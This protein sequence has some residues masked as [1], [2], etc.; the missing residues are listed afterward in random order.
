[1]KLE[2]FVKQENV[3]K[4]N[5]AL[6]IYVN[7][8]GKD[9]G[10]TVRKYTGILIDEVIDRTPPFKT[11]GDTE[12]AKTIGQKALL[13]D[14]HKTVDPID[15]K[16]FDSRSIQKLI[17]EKDIQGFQKALDNFPRMRG[18]KVV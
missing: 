12:S 4:F 9:A 17:R 14:I 13:R 15:W 6:N 16:S 18:N 5:D 2:M 1:M 7:G 10:E 8:F 11:K 3:R